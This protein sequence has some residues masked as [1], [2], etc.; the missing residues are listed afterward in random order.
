MN[1][2]LLVV[3]GVVSVLAV[4]FLSRT[5]GSRLGADDSRYTTGK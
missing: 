4:V 3:L 5:L 1:R 2:S